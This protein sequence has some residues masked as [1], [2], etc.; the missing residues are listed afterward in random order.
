MARYPSD[1]SCSFCI[2]QQL[3]LHLCYNDVNQ[4]SVTFSISKSV[5]LPISFFTLEFNDNIYQTRLFKKFKFHKIFSGHKVPQSEGQPPACTGHA[6]WSRCLVMP[7]RRRGA[8]CW[9]QSVGVGGALARGKSAS[10]PD[11]A[12]FFKSSVSLFRDVVSLLN[13]Q[14]MNF[15]YFFKNPN[16]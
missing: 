16:C 2:S 3:S 9:N 8:Y 4:N 1:L 11:Y 10:V 12:P 13:Y 6:P 7:A 15:A 5:Y 14:R